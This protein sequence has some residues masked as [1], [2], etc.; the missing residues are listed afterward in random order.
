MATEQEKKEFKRLFDYPKA[1]SDFSATF[2]RA[3]LIDKILRSGKEPEP[4]LV[5]LTIR[6]AD[7]CK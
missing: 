2:Q 7:K 4:V 5:Q 3:D 6:K 1:F